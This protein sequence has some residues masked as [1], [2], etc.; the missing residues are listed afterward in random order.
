[1]VL[2]NMNNSGVHLTGCELD[3]DYFAAGIAR[4]KRETAQLTLF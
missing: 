3:P 4:V 2:R 1:M